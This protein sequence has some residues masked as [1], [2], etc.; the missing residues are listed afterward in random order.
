MNCG[1]AT[2]FLPKFV[3]FPSLRGL[4][5]STVQLRRAPMP[6]RRAPVRCGSRPEPGRTAAGARDRLPKSPVDARG[7]R[8]HGFGR[9]SSGPSCP[10]GRRTCQDPPDIARRVCGGSTV[11]GVRTRERGARPR[12]GPRARWLRLPRRASGRPRVSC[13]R[14][15]SRRHRPRR[16]TNRLRRTSRRRRSFPRGG[17]RR[18]SRS[19]LRPTSCRCCR[20]RDASR[21]TPPPRGRPSAPDGVNRPCV[22]ETPAPPRRGLRSPPE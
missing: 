13:L 8:S 3:G 2:A 4:H 15:R 6:G 18:T 19:L 10:T 9:P 17:R 5:S 14:R 12:C 11:R 1:A 22:R 21:W 20:C 7:C 16:R